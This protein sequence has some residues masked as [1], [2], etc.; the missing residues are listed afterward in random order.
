MGLL[1]TDHEISWQ[2]REVVLFGEG[3]PWVFA[4]SILPDELCQ[5][6]L[7]RLGKRPLGKII[8]NDSRFQRSPFDVCDIDDP[9]PLCQKLN[10]KACNRL[11]GRRS[12]FRYLH[13]KMMVAEI[14]LPDSPAYKQMIGTRVN[15]DSQKT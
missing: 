15:V 13:H 12:V 10:I 4:R 5:S 11:W 8:F 7:A 2:V 3:K 14:F 1:E 9:F 6:D